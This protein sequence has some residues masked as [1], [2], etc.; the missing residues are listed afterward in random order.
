MYGK[1]KRRKRGLTIENEILPIDFKEINLKTDRVVLEDKIVI[2]WT[3]K[4]MVY[5][6]LS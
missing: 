2:N 6:L 4:T 3:S 5:D 1:K